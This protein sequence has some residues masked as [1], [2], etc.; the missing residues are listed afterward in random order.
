MAST[1]ET[2]AITAMLVS[3]NRKTLFSTAALLETL[4]R[5]GAKPLRTF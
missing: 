3:T 5:R 4:D 2:I 1:I